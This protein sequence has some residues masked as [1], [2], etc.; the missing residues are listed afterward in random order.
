M[1]R[2]TKEGGHHYFN[3][4][5]RSHQFSGPIVA[6]HVGCCYSA[7]PLAV[8][9]QHYKCYHPDRSVLSFILATQ[10]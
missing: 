10:K 6:I 5:L 8:Q 2:R 1:R 7:T 4:F 3:F 9:R